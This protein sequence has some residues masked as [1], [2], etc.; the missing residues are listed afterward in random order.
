M[1]IVPLTRTSVPLARRFD[2]LFDDSFERIVAPSRADARVPALDVAET[3]AGYTARLDLPGV[4]KDD[5]KVSIEGRLVTVQAQA[6]K[7]EEKTDGDRIIYRERAA[8]SYTRTFKLP[9][10]VD[11]AES[12]AKLE[13][14][15]LT[16][17]LRKRALPGAGQITVN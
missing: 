15:V 3:E 2:R 10:E 4:A 11:Q 17:T 5:V 13:N 9:A 8:A 1:F 12:G 16:L 14:G 7:T 6:Q